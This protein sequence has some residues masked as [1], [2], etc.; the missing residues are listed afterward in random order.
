MELKLDLDFLGKDRLSILKSV[1]LTYISGAK[2]YLD[3][4]DY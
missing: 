1:F 4:I 2:T 3:Q